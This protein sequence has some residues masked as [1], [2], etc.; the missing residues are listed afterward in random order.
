MYAQAIENCCGVC[1]IGEFYD[2]AKPEVLTQRLK[3]TI[4]NYLQDGWEYPYYEDSRKT[5]YITTNFFIATT[6]VTDQPHMVAPL[7]AL[8]FRKRVFNS[9]HG[10]TVY[11]W[12]RRGLPK[13]IQKQW[14]SWVRKQLKDNYK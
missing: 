14:K 5:A 13:E 12:T 2:R 10:G 6:N 3:E 9:K 8:G 4:L 1:E 7:E 11:F